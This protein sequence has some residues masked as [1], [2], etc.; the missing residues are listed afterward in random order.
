MEEKKREGLTVREISELGNKYR[1]EVFVCLLLLLTC[2][3][4]FIFIGGSLSILTA[5]IGGIIGTL[6]SPKLEPHL[7]AMVKYP[8]QQSTTVQLIIAGAVLLVGIFLPLVIFLVLG[9]YAG[10]TIYK[11]ATRS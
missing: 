1:I 7:K 11:F 4:N 6:L 5:T 8:L 2:I 3:F 9:L 10:V